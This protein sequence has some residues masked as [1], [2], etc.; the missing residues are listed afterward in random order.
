[1][2]KLKPKMVRKLLLFEIL[3][4]L[5]IDNL[6]VMDSYEEKYEGVGY[7]DRHFRGMLTRARKQATALKDVLESKYSYVNMDITG[8]KLDNKLEGLMMDLILTMRK[9]NPLERTMN[10]DECKKGLP[11]TFSQFVSGV[12][13]TTDLF[14]QRYLKDIQDEDI[15]KEFVKYTKRVETIMDKLVADNII[16]YI[17]EN[18]QEVK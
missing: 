2:T 17:D 16:W 7:V 4:R 1:M 14:N 6:K 13:V 5:N 10:V 12:L 8:T 11:K 3:Q 9:K 18:T 15:K